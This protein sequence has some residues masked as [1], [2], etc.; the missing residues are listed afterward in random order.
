MSDV[1][2]RGAEELSAWID[3]DLLPDESA[4]IERHV[5][6]C[7][8]CGRSVRELRAVVAAAGELGV[9]EPEA[10]LWP[11]LE[12]RLTGSRPRPWITMLVGLAA[13]LLLSWALDLRRSTGPTEPATEATGERF[14]LVL[15]ESPELLADASPEEIAAVVDRYRNWADDLGSRGKLE[16]GEKLANAEGRWLRDENGTTTVEAREQRGGLGGFFVIRA[17]DYD[18]AVA[19]SRTCPHLEYGGWIELRRIEET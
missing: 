14:V 8:E 7:A 2:H 17:V 4:A 1:E 6:A 5:A 9:S 11:R 19:I 3:G 12:R 16:G 18:E 15:H 10:D 13:G